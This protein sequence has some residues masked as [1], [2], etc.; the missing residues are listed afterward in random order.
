MDKTL[1]QTVKSTHRL[2]IKYMKSIAAQVGIPNSYRLVLT[3]LLHHPG[4]SQKEIA[5]FRHITTA[6]VSQIVK[7]MELTGYLRRETDARDQR[8]VHLYLTEKGA[9]CAEELHRRLTAADE[10]ITQVLTPEKEQE[11]VG[12]LQELSEIIEKEL[13]EC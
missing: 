12:L 13:P 10:K 5:E 6:S 8:Y 9:A 4:A 7:E 1:M 11:L 2:W 3:F